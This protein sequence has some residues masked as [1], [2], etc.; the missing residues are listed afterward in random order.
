LSQAFAA[1]KVTLRQY[2]LVSRLA[3]QQQRERIAALNREIEGAQV[4]A[5]TI[6]EILDCS[7]G[8][9]DPVRLT[10]VA[11]SIREAVQAAHAL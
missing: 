11:R 4:A 6:D 10:E 7:K 2:D 1:C 8:A 3:S 5:R 9:P